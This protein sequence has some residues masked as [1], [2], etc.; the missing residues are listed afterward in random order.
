MS[1]NLYRS[2]A[3]AKNSRTEDV[4]Q[5]PRKCSNLTRSEAVAFVRVRGEIKKHD[6]EF[7]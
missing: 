7:E 6:F 5:L 4:V 3:S 2:A 1:N